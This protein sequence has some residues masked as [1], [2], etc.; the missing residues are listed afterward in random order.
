MNFHNVNE[1]VNVM[2]GEVLYVMVH[3]KFHLPS[4]LFQAVFMP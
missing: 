4:S 1:K 2:D 3:G